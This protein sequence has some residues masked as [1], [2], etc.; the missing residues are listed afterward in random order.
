MTQKT[1]LAAAIATVGATS[2]TVDSFAG[3]P[4]TGTFTILIEAEQLRVTAGNG[5][6]SWT[7]TRGYAGTTAATHA[8]DSVVTL[9]PA[10]LAELGDAVAA[11]PGLD[12][13]SHYDLLSDLLVD[14]TWD[15]HAATMRSFLVPTA[16]VT[17]TVDIHEWSNSLRTAACGFRTTDGQALDIVSVTTLEVRD[18]ETSSYRTI[19]SGDTGY[20]LRSG[21]SGTG[22]A[23]TDWPWEDIHLSPAGT[24]TLFP[25]G[26]A[27]VRIVGRLGFPAI[28]PVAK[29]GC[30]GEVRERFRQSVSG[31]ALPAG[32][33]QFGTPIFLTGA[34]PEMRKLLNH[35][36]TLRPMAA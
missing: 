27:A 24:D 29:R 35:P 18:S 31:G 16:D 11:I 32:I 8:D 6:L 25:T 3:F 13:T 15:I 26:Y 17:V 20:Y 10:A 7:V 34:S 33:N 2:I 4:S 5:T 19:A 21:P 23:G 1:S 9:I 30:I 28:H 22:V 14:V 12:G 36:F